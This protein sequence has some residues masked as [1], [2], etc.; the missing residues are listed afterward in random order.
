MRINEYQQQAQKT[1]IYP[2]CSDFHNELYYPGMGF[3]D[4]IGEVLQVI[5]DAQQIGWFSSG[6]RDS[7]K[8]EAGDV[9]WYASA[10]CN[11]INATLS[12]VMVA[13][14]FST[15]EEWDEWYVE[16]EGRSLI[17]PNNYLGYLAKETMPLAGIIKKVYRDHDGRLDSYSKLRITMLIRRV[18]AALGALLASLDIKMNDAA[19]ANLDKLFDRKERGKLQGDGDNR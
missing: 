2:S 18:M 11:E 14:D 6:H 15:F 4:E 19:Q 17:T 16:S 5:L 8:K 10:L 1:A 12:F 3:I 9:L 13:D 7:L